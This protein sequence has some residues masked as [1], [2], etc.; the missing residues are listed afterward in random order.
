MAASKL[1]KSI[2]PLRSCFSNKSKNTCTSRLS[3][4]S[5]KHC[6]PPNCNQVRSN[7]RRKGNRPWQSKA[8]ASTPLACCKRMRPSSLNRLKRDSSCMAAQILSRCPLPANACRSAKFK[9]HHGAR[10]TFNQWVRSARCIKAHNKDH[11]SCTVCRSFKGSISS[12]WK[13][14]F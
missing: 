4:A 10:N 12:A 2:W 5:T 14:R 7:Q 1:A 8:A 13:C 3:P 9:P 11:A 6:A